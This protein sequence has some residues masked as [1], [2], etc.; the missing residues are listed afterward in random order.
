MTRG[1]SPPF[2]QVQVAVPQRD[3]A[4]RMCDALV[5]ERLAAAAQIVGPVRS[6]YWW[7][8]GFTVAEEWLCLLILSE[9]RY[10]EL[11]RRV[12]ELHP[13]EVPEIVALPFV[14]GNRDYLAWIADETETATETD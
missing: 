5:R 7:Q 11:E 6:S 9:L 2:V 14:R 1:E 10:P 3:A 12:V 8:G 13:Y 4:D